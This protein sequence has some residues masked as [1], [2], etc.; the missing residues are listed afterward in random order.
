MVNGQYQNILMQLFD[1]NTIKQLKI[2]FRW[3][4]Q[5]K[6]LTDVKRTVVRVTIFCSK[7]I[8][9][10]LM[11]I[12]GLWTTC[13]GWDYLLGSK[14]TY[15]H[16]VT[17]SVNTCSCTSFSKYMKT[18]FVYI[19]VIWYWRERSLSQTYIFS[20]FSHFLFFGF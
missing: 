16:H 9:F 14:D 5:I 2:S 11:G 8:F 1:R 4:L 13:E 15:S 17:N 7:L 19:Y 18:F 12:N 3:L 10:A 6:Y 20:C